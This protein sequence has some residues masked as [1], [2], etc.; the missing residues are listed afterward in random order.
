MLKKIAHQTPVRIQILVVICE[1]SEG[2]VI[3]KNTPKIQITAG[4]TRKGLGKS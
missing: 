4:Q 2:Q 1:K 3:D